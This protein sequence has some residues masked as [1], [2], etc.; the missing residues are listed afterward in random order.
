MGSCM[1]CRFTGIVVDQAKGVGGAVVPVMF[2]SL[3][4]R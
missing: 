1:F 2:I 4:K 3:G